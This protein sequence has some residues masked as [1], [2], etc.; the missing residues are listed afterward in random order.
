MHTARQLGSTEKCPSFFAGVSQTLGM[1]LQP[2][3]NSVSNHMCKTRVST[4]RCNQAFFGQFSA[5]ST[6]LKLPVFE[7]FWNFGLSFFKILLEF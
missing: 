3:R 4:Y 2:Y 7:F 6:E 5:N 1:I